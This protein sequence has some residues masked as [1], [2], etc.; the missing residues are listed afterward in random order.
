[1]GQSVCSEERSCPLPGRD[2]EGRAISRSSTG[3][4]CREEGE[5]LR[6]SGPE[7]PPAGLFSPMTRKMLSHPLACLT[8]QQPRSREG[9][10]VH[11]KQPRDP[12]WQRLSHS[13][14]FSF[15]GDGEGGKGG[16]QSQ[17]CA[18]QDRPLS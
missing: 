7:V 3:S 11:S 17:C 18:P 14:E 2:A 1:M 4:E 5:A 13:Q 12:G 10:T 16:V 8:L 9:A 6:S 15:V